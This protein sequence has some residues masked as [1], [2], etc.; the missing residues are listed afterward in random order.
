[1]YKSGFDGDTIGLWDIY[2]ILYN[3]IHI[4]IMGYIMV[5]NGI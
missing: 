2:T 1:M 5:Y 3:F 4:Y